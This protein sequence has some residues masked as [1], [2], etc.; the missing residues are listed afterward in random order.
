M[1]V[2]IDAKP[3]ELQDRLPDLL[4]TIQRMAGEDLAKGHAHDEEDLAPL[5]PVLKEAVA[6]GAFGSPSFFVG[7]KLFFGNDRMDFLEAAI[8]A[9]K[10]GDS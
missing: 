1:K 8:L 4:K 5:I 6:R 7:R 3:G 9:Q 10:E 2:K